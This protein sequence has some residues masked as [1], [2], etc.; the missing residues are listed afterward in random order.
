MQEISEGL[1]DL[2]LGGSIAD[3]VPYSLD[4]FDKAAFWAKVADCVHNVR[5][6]LALLVLADRSCVVVLVKLDEVSEAPVAN[7][8]IGLLASGTDNIVRTGLKRW[9]KSLLA[10]GIPVEVECRD[11]HSALVVWL[12]KI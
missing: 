3:F 9:W 12:V 11:D 4:E 2:F 5:D 1:T 10:I 8:V 7:V 6:N